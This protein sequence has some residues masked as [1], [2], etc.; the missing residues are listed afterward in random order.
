MIVTGASSLVTGSSK[1]ESVKLKGKEQFVQNHVSSEELNSLNNVV[2]IYTLNVMP[3]TATIAQNSFL[4]RTKGFRTSCTR[5]LPC[6][7]LT[8]ITTPLAI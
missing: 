3:F 8:R 6:G 1:N 5:I 7:R 2:H 4:V